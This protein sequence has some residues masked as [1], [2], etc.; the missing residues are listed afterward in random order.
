MGVSPMSRTGLGPVPRFCF[1][2][3]S[4]AMQRVL[5][6][7]AHGDD[8]LLGMGGTMLLHTRHWGDQV[9]LVMLTDGGSAQYADK[10]L[11]R[12]R[13]EEVVRAHEILGVTD[14]HHFDFPDMRLD[15]VGHVELNAAIEKHVDEFQPTMV[16][17]I[18]PDVN[19]DHQ[20]V[21][22]SCA[23][24]VRPVPNQPVRKFITY[25]PLSSTEWDLPATGRYFS[26]N[27]F[28]DIATT[29]EDKCRAMA[30]LKTELRTFPHPRSLEG[31]RV[32]A[33]KEGTRV[34]VAFAE[35]LC[36][37]RELVFQDVSPPH[38]T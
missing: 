15:T 11:L 4:V 32:C 18:H 13:Q 20:C 36:M 34:G 23:V 21:F 14:I 19:M 5:I 31:I 3:V 25:A 38:K 10:N 29:I 2:F 17:C 16:Y 37:L 7:D 35:P 22:N 8:A 6:I 24:A 12:E 1:F 27:L 33:A 26:P 30:R 9:R 28:V